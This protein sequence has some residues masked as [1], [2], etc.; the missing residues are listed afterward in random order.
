LVGID[1]EE[2][3]DLVLCDGDGVAVRRAESE[4]SQLILGG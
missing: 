1:A 3:I 2:L 4:E